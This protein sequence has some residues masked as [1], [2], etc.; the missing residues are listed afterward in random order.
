MLAGLLVVHASSHAILV[1]CAGLAVASAVSMAAGDYLAGKSIRLSLV[2]GLA[3]LAG[4]LVPAVPVVVFPGAAGVVIA[5]LL[6][7]GLGI[8]IAEVRSH[9]GT[10]RPHSY[11]ST[12][13]VLAASSGLAVAVALLL[14]VGG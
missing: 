13:L 9:S 8:G 5:A 14:G 1:A 6:V 7:A 12:F 10:G 4:S 3:T 2:M 11:L